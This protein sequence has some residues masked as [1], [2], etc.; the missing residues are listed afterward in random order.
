MYVYY[1][2]ETMHGI[3]KFAY[4]NH[5]ISLCY[6]I[7]QSILTPI[8]LYLSAMIHAIN[9]S[10]SYVWF[11]VTTMCSCPRYSLSTGSTYIIQSLPDHHSAINV[12]SV[13]KQHGAN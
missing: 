3:N 11:I 6:A 9:Q 4:I 8:T 12:N 2:F 7:N 13:T 1:L 10:I 5:I